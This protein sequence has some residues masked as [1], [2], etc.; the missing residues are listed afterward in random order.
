MRGIL[1]KV[2]SI[3]LVAAAMTLAGC[4]ND[5]AGTTPPAGPAA[6]TGNG[7]AALTADE[8]L[9]RATGALKA[10]KAYHAEGD[11]DLDG[12]PTGIDLTVDGENFT[13]SLTSGKAKVDL[14]DVDGK[15]Y[16]RP[17]EQ[18]WVTAMDAP[19]A[20]LLA[21]V[22]GDR[23]VTAAEGDQ[24]FAELFSIGSAEEFLKPTGTLTK[25]TEKQI[26]GVP[27]IALEDQQ[28]TLYIATTGEPYPL[29]IGGKDGASQVLFSDF[30]AP[31]KPIEPPAPAQVI[32][33]G[34]LSGK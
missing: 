14:L 24:S 28:A 1:P 26:G 25:G 7:V 18:F 6:P 21:K 2:A 11:I 13:A 33:L 23:W 5:K 12:Q 8:I 29:R 15:R 30:N 3:T 20:K 27:A 9:Q 16:M 22:I 34:A 10:A 4:Q 17:N 19:K 31:A 32:D